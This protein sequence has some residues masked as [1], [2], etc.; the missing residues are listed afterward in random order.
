M[1]KDVIINVSRNEVKQCV[2][3]KIIQ[4]SIINHRLKIN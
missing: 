3:T 4:V 2:T 1:I